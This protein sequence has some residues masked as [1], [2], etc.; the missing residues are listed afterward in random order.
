MIDKP[1]VKRRLF[2]A[3]VDQDFDPERDVAAGPWCF[4]GQESINCDWEELPYYN[5]FPSPKDQM[6]A[7]RDTRLLANHI[8]WSMADDL[9]KEHGTGYSPLFWRNN[10]IIWLVAAVQ[11]N[12]RCYKNLDLLVT[13]NHKDSFMVPVLDDVPEWKFASLSEFMEALNH[14]AALNFWMS[15]ALIRNLAP[16]YWSFM[17]TKW[18]KDDSPVRIKWAR[19]QTTRV[20]IGQWVSRFGFGSVLGSKFSRPLFSAIISVLPRRPAL[21]K[22]Q[23][24]N[25]SILKI[26]PAPFLESL[27]LFLQATRPA[28]FGKNFKAI[29]R[30]ARKFSYFPGRITVTAF[31]ADPIDQMITALAVENGERIIGLQHG[32]WHGMAITA[33]WSGETEHTHEGAISWGWKK[34]PNISGTATPLPS[35]FLSS[36]YNKHQFLTSDLILVGTKIM[37]QNDRIESRPYSKQWLKYRQMKVAFINHLSGDIRR[38]VGYRPYFMAMEIL[39]EAAYLERYFPNLKIHSGPLINDILGCRLLVLDHPG[40]T[41]HI[42][43]AANIPTICYWDPTSW[44]MSPNAQPLLDDMIQAGILFTDPLSAAHNINAIWGDVPGWWRSEAVQRARGNWSQLHA[45]TSPIWWWHWIRALIHHARYNTLPDEP[46]DTS[47][48]GSYGIT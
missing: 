3:R 16:T 44:P 21:R 39:Q 18:K 36:L 2:T 41:L 29:E 37:I 17:P 15:S 11:A 26:F 23:A 12:W 24:P 27:A 8:A 31:T 4:I 33:P 20:R 47:G 38:Y 35:P 25:D 46:N 28:S 10:L 30:V 7:D 40:T 34:Q 48:N 42:A 13:A 5:P 19:P 9:N 32:A 43:M 6:V 14:N 45:R 22:P 1:T